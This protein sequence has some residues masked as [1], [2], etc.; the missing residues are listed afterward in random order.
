M[1]TVPPPNVALP[2][3]LAAAAAPTTIIIPQPPPALAAVPAGTII[4]A[5]VLP[6]PPQPIAVE[7]RSP[8][9]APAAGSNAAT[10]PSPQIVVLH[11]AVGDLS[12]R[13]PISL[14][15][16]AEV[17][18]EVVRATPQQV[19]VRL[20]T[21]DG[22]PATQYLAQSR[23]PVAPVATPSPALT[24]VPTQLSVGPQPLLP[25]LSW[26][27]GGPAPFVQI[28][29]ISAIVT[30]VPALP[31]T[32]RTPAAPGATPPPSPSTPSAPPLPAIPTLA[33]LP[34]GTGSELALKI[35]SVQL[36]GMPIVG[37]PI[38]PAPVPGVVSPVVASPQIAAQPQ[39]P[40]PA[41]PAPLATA[42]VVTPAPALTPPTP[43]PGLILASP[44][45]LPAAPPQPPAMVQP[46]APL[47]TVTGTVIASADSIPVVEIEGRQV[48]LNARA[49][50]PVG[51]KLMFDVTA[52]TP[53]RAGAALPLPVPASGPPLSGPAGAFTGWP[54]LSESIRVL[55]R[56]D[57][58][59]A[60]QL[61]QAIPDGG[62]RTAAAAISFVQA[63]RSGDARQ[64]P[65][66]ASLRA[67]ERAGPRGAHLAAT[68][69]GEVA[70]LAA[71]S[72]D[73]GTEWRALPIPWSAGGEIERVAL[74][75]RREGEGEGE[76]SREKRG[77]GTR[78][79][80]DLD[81]SRLG[82]MQLDGMFKNDARAFDMVLRTK[83]ELPDEMRRDLIGI[84][85]DANG[86][87]GLKGTLTFQVTRKFAD[88]LGVGNTPD[89]S[90][91]WA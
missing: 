91:L 28:G 65:G 36:P 67:L 6:P 72:R 37:A 10:A 39:A 24:P 12:V 33:S 59:A 19:T 50:L 40:A 11:T 8:A 18:L 90:G 57:P 25:G 13:L 51:T 5:V 47:A 86:A 80:I 58:P 35:V 3:V 54:T 55:Q 29:T 21:I 22:A 74:I 63:L 4:E 69:S 27:P 84:F 42:Q 77:G 78:F 88:P 68:L 31:D 43:Q 9:N 45:G 70:E 41:P 56:G 66:D 20:T 17:E 73:S 15:S 23:A 1:P 82:P 83:V 79:L 61:A 34:V 16:R 85:A 14:P 64:W 38:A 76:E 44:Q 46:A 49:N 71:R 81:L 87:M 53:P 32:T 89:K 30:Q 52:A 48:Q 7:T 2:Q 26:T 75:T 62:P 60:Q